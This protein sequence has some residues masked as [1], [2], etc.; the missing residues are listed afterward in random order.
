[1][2]CVDLTDMRGFGFFLKKEQMLVRDVNVPFSRT[3]T[4]SQSMTVGMRCAMLITV[5]EENSLRTVC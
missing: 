4:L 3:R 1:M 2:I 5:H